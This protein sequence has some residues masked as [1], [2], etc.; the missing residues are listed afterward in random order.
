MAVLGMV[1]RRRPERLRKSLYFRKR[2]LVGSQRGEVLLF[3]PLIVRFGAVPLVG[4]RTE[5][6]PGGGLTGRA[7]A[8]G[9][10]TLPGSER[11]NAGTRRVQHR[12][13]QKP[14]FLG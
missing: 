2:V 5:S 10:S 4:A 11:D 6:P 9:A 14:T 12:P 1:G 3:R 8:C 7:A 13:H